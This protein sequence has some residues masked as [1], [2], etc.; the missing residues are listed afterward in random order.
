MRKW[1]LVFVALAGSLY[2]YLLQG[3]DFKSDLKVPTYASRSITQ[4][5][6]NINTKVVHYK[7][8][9][10]K[11][12]T[13]KDLDDIE[14]L[15]IDRASIPIVYYKYENKIRTA[16]LDECVGNRFKL[17]SAGKGQVVL[18]DKVTNEKLLFSVK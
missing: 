11:T 9:E 7:D 16:K 18:Q 15:G 3:Y 4:D 2:G 5:N 17:E 13:Y 6:S 14:I 8:I 10:I 1:L 12:P